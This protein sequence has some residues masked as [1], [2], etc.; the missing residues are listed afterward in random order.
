MTDTPR[1]AVTDHSSHRL[2]ARLA[3]AQTTGRLP[4]VV[5]GLVRDGEPVWS[6][7]YGSAGV[8]DHDPLDVQYRIGSITKTMTA[9]L[10]LQL[11]RDA[12]IGL[13]DAA[14]TV[15]GDLGGNA[16]ADRSLRQ[17]LAHSTSGA[18]D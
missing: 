5:A 6:G 15:L 14:S 2:L 4:S 7:S 10:I 8:P 16:Y 17:L 12:R 13:D 1:K 11:V 3:H 9:V 18:C